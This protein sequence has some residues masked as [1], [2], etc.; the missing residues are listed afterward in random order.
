MVGAHSR[1]LAPTSRAQ[2]IPT[3]SKLTGTVALVTGTSIGIGAA[4]R[5]LADTVPSSCSWPA[6]KAVNNLIETYK[7]DAIWELMYFGHPR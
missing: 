2:D 7:D 6:A 1:W 3:T 4:A 5:K